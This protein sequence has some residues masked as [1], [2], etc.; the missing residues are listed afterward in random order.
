MELLTTKQAGEILGISRRRVIALI[1]QGKLKAKKFS[2]VYAISPSDVASVR[3]RKNGR[4]H[5]RSK[6]LDKPFKTIF[7]LMPALLEPL[8]DDLPYDLSNKKKYLKLWEF[9]TKDDE[10]ARRSSAK[11]SK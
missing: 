6:E 3:D 2:N 11:R 5:T 8:D 4:P 10:T 1:E 7:D 9:G